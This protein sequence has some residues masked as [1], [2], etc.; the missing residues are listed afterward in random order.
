MTPPIKIVIAD[1]HPPFSDSLRLLLEIEPDFKVIGQAGNVQDVVR[2]VSD[3]QPDILLL[4]LKMPLR[5]KS[6]IS[7]RGGL[8]ALETL[9][10]MGSQTKTIFFAAEMDTEEIFEAMELGVRGVLLKHSATQLLIESIRSVMSGACWDETK[11]VAS[12]QPTM[13]RMREE[14]EKRRFGLTPSELKVASAI[15]RHGMTNKDIA[16][17][18]KIVENTVKKHITSI[19]NK[20]GASSRLELDHFARNR[21][22]PLKDLF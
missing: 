13:Q 16:N 5:P 2:Q 17:F 21:K 3:L 10:K 12:L 15:V 9:K 4:D 14:L 6:G 19:F 18:F 20:L 8:D 7:S 1:D 11:E 22:L